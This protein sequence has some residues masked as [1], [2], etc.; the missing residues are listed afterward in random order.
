MRF[1]SYLPRTS[2]NPV[3]RALLI[4]A[5]AGLMVLLVIFGAAALMVLLLAG[6]VT[7]AVQ[8]WRARHG[9]AAAATRGSTP[10]GPQVLEGEYVVV[11]NTPPRG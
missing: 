3:L 9:H 11:D 8:R 5:G 2:M 1:A 4:V 7:L 6:S 10:H